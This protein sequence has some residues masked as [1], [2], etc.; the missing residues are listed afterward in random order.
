VLLA[1]GE[2]VDGRRGITPCPSD[3]SGAR[4]RHELRFLGSLL[5]PADETVFS[6]FQGTEADV[7]AIAQEADIP[8]E[9]VVEWCWLD[10]GGDDREL[11]GGASP[12][13]RR[14]EGQR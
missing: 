9:R 4:T 7:R 10:N 5:I 13:L 6:L 3:D 2:R 12:P 8:L 11:E 1:G 14:R